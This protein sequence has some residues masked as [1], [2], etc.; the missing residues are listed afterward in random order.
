MAQYPIME[1]PTRDEFVAFY[2]V[3]R[4]FEEVFVAETLDGMEPLTDDEFHGL[5][6]WFH[7]ADFGQEESDFICYGYQQIVRERS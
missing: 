2:K 1:E 7:K 4:Y 3:Q 5:V 6:N